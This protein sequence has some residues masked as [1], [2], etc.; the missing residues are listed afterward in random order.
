M[1]VGTI[2]IFCTVS[3]AQQPNEVVAAHK[4]Q[5]GMVIVCVVCN[6]SGALLVPAG[7]RITSSTATRIAA[8]LGEKLIEV[9]P[10]AA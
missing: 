6:D 5:E 9:S 1:R 4:L 10:L 2:A 3:V 8:A 7:T